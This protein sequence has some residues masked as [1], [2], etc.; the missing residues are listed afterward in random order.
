LTVWSGIWLK[1]WKQRF[2]LII[3][4]TGQ[5]QPCKNEAAKVEA[6][7]LWSKLECK[8]EMI[9]MV[10]FGLIRNSEVCGTRIIAEDILRHEVGRIVNP[11]VSDSELLLTVLNNALF[12][13]REVSQRFGP[14]V[15]IK[16]EKTYYSE[17]TN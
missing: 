2:N 3:G 6:N 9:E 14:L 15:S 8:E 1:K 11:D 12:R 4:P 7:D 10:V 5:K 13:A 16:V 17:V